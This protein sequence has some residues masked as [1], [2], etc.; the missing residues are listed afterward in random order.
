VPEDFAQRAAQYYSEK[1]LLH[2]PTPAGVDWNSAASQICR[3]EQ[4]T[5]ICPAGPNP[6]GLSRDQRERLNPRDE[7]FS[8]LDFGCGYGALL[9]FL[10]ERSF[11]SFYWG[12]D[13][14]PAMVRKAAEIHSGDERARFAERLDEVPAVDYTIASGVFN[15]KHQA[16]AQEWKDYVLATLGKMVALSRKGCAFNLLTGYSDP[17]RMRDD[18]YYADPCFFFDFCKTRFCRKVALLHDYELY[19]FTILMRME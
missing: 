8:L 15:V 9:T 7:D 12:Y 1:L 10:R 3:F 16:P 2:G 14:A 17:A 11:R 19:E 18:L 4:L 5:R 6:L 13:A